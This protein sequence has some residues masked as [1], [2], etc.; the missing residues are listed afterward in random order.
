MTHHHDH[1]HYT[2]P[3]TTGELRRRFQEIGGDDA[4]SRIYHWVP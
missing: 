2:D 3:M 1:D 4:R